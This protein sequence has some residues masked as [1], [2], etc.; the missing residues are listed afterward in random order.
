MIS[1]KKIIH[2]TL[3][4][5]VTIFSTK[6]IASFNYKYR[7]KRRSKVFWPLCLYLELIDKNDRFEV[8]INAAETRFQT[9]SRYQRLIH[10]KL[11]VTIMSLLN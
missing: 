2:E 8:L 11:L 7:F 1:S 9:V 5:L 3:Q 10:C 6:A 4:I